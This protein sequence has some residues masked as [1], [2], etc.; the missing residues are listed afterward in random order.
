MAGKNGK[1]T[2]FWKA[3]VKRGAQVLFSMLLMFGL[4]FLS[5]GRTDLPGA[6]LFFG[7]YII[8]LFFNMLIFLKYNP[9]VIEARSEMLKGRMK[10][11][12]KVYAWL[13]IILMFALPVVCGLDVRSGA[14]LGIGYYLAG[15]LL[16]I[17]GWTFTSWALVVNKFF[18]GVVRIQKER[19]HRV[20]TIG[21]YAIVR[22]PGYLGMI[23]FYAA[24][25]LGFGSLYG[26]VPALL[27]AAAFV[28]RTHFEDEFLQKDL[29]GYKEYAKKVRYR[30]VPGIW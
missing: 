30:L 13:Y 18:E 20:V 7:L 2:V 14:T 26:L 22:H 24:M 6:W 3:A 10:W 15:V 28:F 9:E 1:K 21:P 23:V 29:K 27:L 19:K 5:A 17:A 8:S 16:F 12:D 4:F 11:W 25:P